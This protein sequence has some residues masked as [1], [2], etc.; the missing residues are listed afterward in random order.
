MLPTTQEYK[1]SLMIGQDSFRTLENIEVVP[2][3]NYP[4]E[5]WYSTGGLAI[6]FKIKMGDK[7]YA[8]KCFYNEANERQERLGLIADYLKQNPTPYFV[9]F[10]YLEN[11]IFVE[12]AN[13]GEGYPVVLMEWV[14]GKTLDNYLEEV[15]QQ[16]NKP[17]LQNLYFQFCNLAWWLQ[18]QPVAHGDIKHDNLIVTPDG[19]L[20]LIDYDGVFVPA[21]R[22]R[23]ANEMGSPCY[24]HP[25]RDAYFFDKNLDDFS[26][27]VLQITLLALQ[28]Q[29]KLYTEHYN[30][31][32][33]I[34]KDTDYQ[35]F[36]QSPI[37][38]ILWQLPEVKIPLLL[39]QLQGNLDNLSA[40]DL[41][42]LLQDVEWINW[43][44]GGQ[45][46]DKLG[47]Q[48]QCLK[49]W[50]LKNG[51][52]RKLFTTKISN[53]YPLNE[54]LI[55]KYNEKWDWLKLSWNSDLIW[56]MSLIEKYGNKWN[57]KGLN[58]NSGISWTL[59]LIEEYKNKDDWHWGYK[60]FS[61]NSG[62]PWSLEL[63]EKYKDKWD[64]G[65]HGLSSNFGLPWKLELIERYKDKW[66]W[67]ELGR[68]SGLPWTIILIE[69]YEDKW[70]WKSLSRNRFQWTIELIEKY[71]DKWD[72]KQFGLSSKSGLPWTLELIEKYENKWAWKQFGLSGNS[73]L[74]W[75]LELIEEYEDKWDWCGL[76]ENSGL[77]WS[78]ELIDKYDDRWWANKILQENKGVYE[79]IFKPLLNDE[80][81]EEI[82]KE[83]A[84]I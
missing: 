26:L 36:A 65:C 74:P 53:Y 77:P 79:K 61:S 33:I 16:Q 3:P 67:Y 43:L 24:Q 1:I 51:K 39:S 41:M 76:S 82:M 17:A 4:D 13:G 68:N 56:T 69:K 78:L 75:T 49:D 7:M 31:D 42:P 48:R 8:L 54:K 58:C 12:T 28:Q 66:D 18:Q 38:T 83:I 71:E 64:W 57:M 2:N 5:P 59:E 15:C 45:A 44:V 30:G 6:V 9:D 35:N 80:F 60:G 29:P 14:E 46:G 27:L 40:I 72:W 34:L 47:L 32:G 52:C 19:K 22:G 21:L 50:V 25:Q 70:D 20:K 23:K 81:I 84:K 73:C 63:I 55:E 62:L 37:K 11:E 10:T